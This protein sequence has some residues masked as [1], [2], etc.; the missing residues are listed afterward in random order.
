MSKQAFRGIG[1][2]MGELSVLFSPRRAVVE[3][4]RTSVLV[5]LV[6]AL[7]STGCWVVGLLVPWLAN[8]LHD[9]PG[10]FW[11]GVY[12][13]SY[14]WPYAV[15]GAEA[16]AIGLA[17]LGA[18]TITPLV[19]AASAVAGAAVLVADR[20]TLPPQSRRR[21]VLLTVVSAATA[22]AVFSPFG[23]HLVMWML[24]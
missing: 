13:P 17:A 8:G 4:T 16:A 19:S 15:G 11:G 2:V 10:V 22:A 14:R 24:D 12:D 3:L 18:M 21:L 20:G 5:W 6:A 23:Q 1:V 7:A 9:V